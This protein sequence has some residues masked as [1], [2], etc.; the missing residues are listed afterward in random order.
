[1]S[2]PYQSPQ[3][4]AI[5]V[6][7]ADWRAVTQLDPKAAAIAAQ[8]FFLA[9][10]YRLESGDVRDGTYGIGNNVLRLLFGAFVKRYKFKVQVVAVGDGSN[11]LVSKG[12]SGVMGGAIGYAKMK[13]EL[14]RIREGLQTTLR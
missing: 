3:T 7:K 9:E 2:N 13:K 1:M 10:G 11:V 5:D 4:Q 14:V 6:S 8:D 12:M